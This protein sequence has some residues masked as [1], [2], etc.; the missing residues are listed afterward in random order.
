MAAPRESWEEVGE[1]LSELGLKLKLHVEQAEKGRAEAETEVTDALRSVGDAIDRAFT[2]LGNAV[3][4]DAVREDARDV[5]Q[6][7]IG[8]LDATFSELGERF[9]AVIKRD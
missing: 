4:D 8:A 1:R 9:R 7:M 3:K 2:A 6:S 5:G